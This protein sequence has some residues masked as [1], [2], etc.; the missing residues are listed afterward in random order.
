MVADKTAQQG[1]SLTPAGCVAPHRR[2]YA[3]L[4]PFEDL[5]VP[6]DEE[7]VGDVGPTFFS[8]GVVAVEALD[9]SDGLIGGV[10][11]GSSAVMHQEKPHVFGRFFGQ[12]SGRRKVCPPHAPRLYDMIPPDRNAVHPR[13]VLG[14]GCLGNE[15]TGRGAQAAQRQETAA[16]ERPR[17]RRTLLTH[18]RLPIRW[19]RQL[20]RKQPVIHC[21]NACSRAYLR[22]P[23][24]IP[25]PVPRDGSNKHKPAGPARQ[26]SWRSGEP[27]RRNRAELRRRQANDPAG[28]G[29]TPASAAEYPPPLDWLRSGPGNHPRP[30]SR[31]FAVEAAPGSYTQSP[32]QQAF[33]NKPSPRKAKTPGLPPSPVG[34]EQSKPLI[35]RDSRPGTSELPIHPASW[36]GRG[37]RRQTVLRAFNRD[38]AAEECGHHNRRC[39]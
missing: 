36:R 20:H 9:V 21:S 30:R 5:P 37:P 23:A 4:P 22:C 16:R 6:V 11:V 19:G 8:R 39:A 32:S 25:Q 18:E 15:Q 33:P 12:C 28:G 26:A 38:R 29:W 3:S 24:H 14:G 7:V 1:V 2:P 13:A 27:H 35:T 34:E 31:Y 10:V 17:L